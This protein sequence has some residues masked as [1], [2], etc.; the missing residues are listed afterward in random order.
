MTTLADLD[1]AALAELARPVFKQ[2][3]KDLPLEE[4]AKRR[5][6]RIWT[7]NLDTTWTAK[8]YLDVGVTSNR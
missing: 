1:L 2:Y 8:D 7:D 4:S 6:I 5:L 3:I